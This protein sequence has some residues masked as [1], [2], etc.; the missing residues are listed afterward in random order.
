MVA[1]RYH[2]RTRA[3]PGPSENLRMLTRSNPFGAIMK[4]TPL[5]LRPLTSESQASEN[6]F[7]EVQPVRLLLIELLTSG[8]PQRRVRLRKSTRVKRSRAS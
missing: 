7:V 1:L 5:A 8:A 4:S 6:A 2:T 3:Y